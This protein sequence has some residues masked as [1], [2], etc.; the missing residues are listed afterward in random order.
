MLKS[1]IQI[2]HN[3]SS[4]ELWLMFINSRDKLDD[5]LVAYKNAISALCIH[6]FTPNSNPELDSEYILDLF[7]QLIN[8]LCSS[9]EIENA[10]EKV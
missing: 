6:A 1:V 3:E 5:R 10:I 8:Y 7:L 2:E 9:R 4:Y